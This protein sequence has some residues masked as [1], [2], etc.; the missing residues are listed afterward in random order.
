MQMLTENIDDVI[1]AVL[2]QLGTQGGPPPMT[3]QMVD[4]IPTHPATTE[5]IGKERRV[6]RLASTAVMSYVIVS[7]LQRKTGLVQYVWRILL[8]VAVTRKCLA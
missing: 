5:M 2:N 7:I 4:A 6:E 3:Q 8:P 1:T